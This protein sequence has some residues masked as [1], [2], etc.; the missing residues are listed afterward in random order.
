MAFYATLVLATLIGVLFNFLPIDPIRALYWSAVLNGVIA[1]PVMVIMML[2]A[3]RFK[4]MGQFAIS[5]WL[6]THRLALDRHHGA[7]GRWH[8]RELA[9]LTANNRIQRGFSAP[10]GDRRHRDRR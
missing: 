6:Q 7:R 4:V 8:G 10:G 5:G 1:V 9:A 3:A 2:M